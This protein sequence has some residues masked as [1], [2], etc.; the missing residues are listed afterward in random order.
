MSVK[1]RFLGQLCV[2]YG[3]L[4]TLR[5]VCI[6]AGSVS[7][8]IPKFINKFPSVLDFINKTGSR[9][10]CLT[11]GHPTPT[12]EWIL[13]DGKHAE[14]IQGL[15]QLSSN[16]SLVFH[17]FA[18]QEY[19]QDVHA[20]V[21]R[22]KA[23]NIVGT[24]VSHDVRVRA[25][26]MQT[27]EA[28]VYDEFVI[29]GN[30]AVL[31]CHIPTFVADYVYVTSWRR[32]ESVIYP[33]DKAGAKYSIMP[34]GE[35]HI[36]DV[37]DADANSSYRCFT[38]HRLTGEDRPSATS[39]RLFVTYPLGSVPPR[40]T[41]TRVS[42]VG[43]EGSSAILPCVAQGFPL[44]DITWH[45]KRD[46]DKVSPL[47][48]DGRFDPRP[49]GLR[50]E[51]VTVRDAGVYVCF[52]NN[53]VGSE[54]SE[55][56]LTVVAPLSVH[57]EP[58]SQVCDLGQSASFRCVTQG[59]PV[60]S[61]TWFKDGKVLSIN[62]DGVKRY[63]FVG[64]ETLVIDSVEREDRG[65]YQCLISSDLDSAQAAAEL[66][67]GDIFP[68]MI[69][70][71]PESIVNPGSRV[72]LM[73]VVSGSPQPVIHWTIDDVP[74]NTATTISNTNGGLS[75]GTVLDSVSGNV[76]ST[77]NLSRV[78]EEEGGYYTCTARNKAGEVKHTARI[79]VYGRPFIRALPKISAVAG[80]DVIINCPVTGYPIA[81]ITWERGG[82]ELPISHHQVVFPNGTLQIK[83]I[84]RT[85]DAGKYTCVARNGK[86]QTASRDFEVMIL[87]P[88]HIVPFSFMDEYMLEGMLARLTCVVSRGDRPLTIVWVK[89]DR[90]IT[91][92]LGVSVRTFDEYSVV[93]TINSVSSKHNG[94][95]T[96]IASNPAGSANHTA[97]LIV[98]V[99]P[100]WV[101][102][103]KNVD[104]IV[105]KEIV[106]NC[107]V[108]GF[109]TPVIHWKKAVDN[110]PGEYKAPIVGS[111][112]N[113][114]Q[115]PN[116]SLVI[117]KAEASHAGQYLCQASNGIGAPLGA[118][119]KVHVQVPVYF[120]E[121]SHNQTCRRSER[122][123]LKCEAIGESPIQISWFK[124][125][126]SLKSFSRFVHQDDEIPTGVVSTV[127]I[128]ST[129][130]GD[131]A[132]YTCV[133]SNKYGRD[134]RVIYLTVTEP[135]ETPTELKSS[136]KNSRSLS[137][138]WKAP[139]DGNKHISKYIVQYK[140]ATSSWSDKVINFTVPG[141]ESSTTISFLSPATNYHVR[142][143]ALN[144][145]G[146]SE[147]SEVISV[148]TG[149]EAPGG[150]PAD[151]KVQ[152]IGPDTIKVSWKPPKLELWHGQILGFYVG[153]R[154]YESPDSY[155]FE[156]I[157]VKNSLK[158]VEHV[159]LTGLKKFTR[160]SIV[161]QAYNHVG[162]SP[163]S[164][165]LVILTSEDVPSKAPENVR[166]SAMSSQ[167]LHISWDPL[168]PSAV[169]GILQGY[170]ILYHAV[171]DWHGKLSEVKITSGS[172][173]VLMGLG[174]FTNYSIQVS[175]FTRVGDGVKSLPV[176]CIS[177]E[178]APEA[179][180]DIKVAA[181][182]LTEVLV[183]WKKPI[184]PNGHITK[185]TVYRRT[186]DRDKEDI[187]K[188]AV[189]ASHLH[190]E[191]SGLKKGYHYEF[192][193]T[194]STSI[195]EGQSTRVVTFSPV[196]PVVPAKI[197][198]FGGQLNISWKLP[199]RLPCRAV[200]VPAPEREWRFRGLK[201]FSSSRLTLQ[202]DGDLVIHSSV[203]TDAGSYTC[204]VHNTFATDEISFLIRI[205][206]PPPPPVV[207]I[208]MTTFHSLD[209]RW[210][211]DYSNIEI[212]ITGYYLYYKKDFSEW[213][214]IAIEASQRF[215]S[216]NQLDCGT[217]Y[218]IYVS[219]VNRIGEGSPS[220][221]V[222][223]RTEG[224]VPEAPSKSIFIRE[225]Q[226]FVTLNLEAWIAGCVILYFV[227]YYKTQVESEWRLV[228]NNV[229][230]QQR[231]FVIPDLKPA[232][233]Y[234]LKVIA[235]NNAGSTPREYNFAT[236][237]TLGAPLTKA[238]E[239][240]EVESMP[241][242]YNVTTIIISVSCLITTLALIGV[243]CIC[244]RKRTSWAG[245]D[246]NDIPPPH[247]D[248]RPRLVSEPVKNCSSSSSN[249]LLSS[250]NHTYKKA[251]IVE[252]PT[253]DLSGDISPY[254][255]SQIPGYY[256]R[257]DSRLNQRLSAPHVYP[258]L[259]EMQD[260]RD[261]TYPGTR[262]LTLQ[263]LQQYARPDGICAAAYRKSQI[264]DGSEE[265]VQ[266]VV[267]C[268]AA[269]YGS[270]PWL[271]HQHL[272]S[273]EHNVPD[274]L[275]HSL[276]SNSSVMSSPD[277]DCRHQSLPYEVTL[278]RRGSI[279]SSFVIAIAHK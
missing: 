249:Y 84:Q 39:G 62:D 198:S 266:V 232:T 12:V 172:K 105:G 136:D 246:P 269:E 214:K 122:A 168:A 37:Q 240:M 110:K 112:P 114:K 19:R 188:F 209:V 27:Y 7:S 211:H 256:A 68:A 233:W 261:G 45:V 35:L 115:F 204:K 245:S 56:S 132:T 51:R 176:F 100:R 5:T 234:Q 108:E 144:D 159:N 46:D 147:P 28:L 254:A 155:K 148:S 237:T 98:N 124:N 223:I 93:L 241:F 193:V 229:L 79:N 140:H 129:D 38:K 71:F 121:R 33:S 150:P 145:V 163:K 236:L 258:P 171:E 9:L 90:L 228:S 16:G 274:L 134:E 25:V 279:T 88:P 243:I 97:Q 94:N 224:K 66:T 208:S 92:E 69:Y 86:G 162:T 133:A 156:T 216:L 174:K 273:S 128:I 160:Y 265:D 130:R 201:L 202:T 81:S 213:E 30:I 13:A 43:K 53:T 275:D 60:T 4:F 206:V 195:G 3:C 96:C 248:A 47:W 262:K 272:P 113:V 70:A 257:I 55:M 250:G 54:K 271:T 125:G 207:A 259:I 231:E 227:I 20:T 164:D 165:E 212:P 2:I 170:K 166:C 26:V 116:G 123:A 36:S 77:L 244:C 103:P 138:S 167:S 200:G 31:K 196:G 67:L 192:W 1:W 119:N 161:V 139:F 183:T 181:I 149:E 276:E 50:I 32:G 179:P 277:L 180:P 89:D 18:A 64:R 29:R 102:E 99:P 142:V 101:V 23:T 80:Q 158:D 186:V 44:P 117:Y 267:T 146:S 10:D 255:T 8:T 205:Q 191:S 197:V 42:I 76:V 152:S 73:C 194:A 154:M 72:S 107:Q 221:T 15:R 52:A 78:R 169:N 14:D 21:Y 238:S 263:K 126:I 74:V 220:E 118:V 199:I 82:R 270:E 182:A 65:V 185:Y 127:Q 177:N 239:A 203:V 120:E 48:S 22:C 91:A 217:R 242:Y 40:I 278:Q 6:S 173:T 143:I 215:Y 87:V 190:Y 218:H 222:T 225:S 268:S 219:A 24:I 59:N 83:N 85:L 153:Y 57:I 41:D 61:M 253:S 106:L 34:T 187:E 189:S 58:E 137:L 49:S 235:H 135:P 111:D 75:V 226:T 63:G 264:V 184:R 131:S 260:V 95:Y 17:P 109:P 230:L 157:E 252:T 11:S 151:V 141:S 178:D 247:A 175:G 104:V 210:K 251:N